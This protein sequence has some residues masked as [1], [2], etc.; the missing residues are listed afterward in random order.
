MV[1]FIDSEKDFATLKKK[2]PHAKNNKEVQTKKD[3]SQHDK[4][5]I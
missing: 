3:I 1:I 4:G 5:Y 2:S